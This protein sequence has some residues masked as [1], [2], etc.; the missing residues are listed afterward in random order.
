MAKTGNIPRSEYASR[1]EPQPIPPS[2]FASRANGVRKR[3]S[4]VIDNIGQIAPVGFSIGQKMVTNPDDPRATAWFDTL[5]DIADDHRTIGVGRVEDVTLDLVTESEVTRL[6]AT[7]IAIA[8]QKRETITSVPELSVRLQRVAEEAIRDAAKQAADQKVAAMSIQR[9]NLE[10]RALGF[11]NRSSLDGYEAFV[12]PVAQP[13]AE[14]PTSLPSYVRTFNQK[15]SIE[16]RLYMAEHPFGISTY[17]PAAQFR[18]S[19]EQDGWCFDFAPEGQAIL[20]QRRVI[21]NAAYNALGITTVRQ[22]NPIERGYRPLSQFFDLTPSAEAVAPRIEP[23]HQLV[24]M[25]T[26]DVGIPFGPP[27]ILQRATVIE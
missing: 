19:T 24:V 7:G 5:A 14:D 27:Q 25:N 1:R 15:L 20:S 11:I 2:S 10:L 8:R 3:Q 16:D 6:I 18:P 23:E 21:L 13:E 12:L 4:S 9:P 26:P 17:T 22:K